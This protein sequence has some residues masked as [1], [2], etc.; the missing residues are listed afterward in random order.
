MQIRLAGG[1]PDDDDEDAADI[2]NNRK[3]EAEERLNNPLKDFP[4]DIKYLTPDMCE[5]KISLSNKYKDR[6]AKAKVWDKFRSEACLGKHGIVAKRC[7]MNDV[8]WTRYLEYRDKLT[9]D[10]IKKMILFDAKR[11]ELYP[12]DYKGDGTEPPPE[13]YL[14]KLK[15]E[16]KLEEIYSKLDEISKV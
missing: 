10:D 12:P 13:E 1:N 5:N 3:R 9:L 8:L 6:M 16:G 15:S 7:S 4:N 14:D 11:R 2:S